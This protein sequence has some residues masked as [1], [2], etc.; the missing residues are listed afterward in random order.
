MKFTDE[1]IKKALSLLEEAKF[2]ILAEEFLIRV[3]HARQ[4]Y[5]MLEE[6]LQKLSRLCKLFPGKV[7]QLKKEHEQ[8]KLEIA[9]EMLKNSLL[10]KENDPSSI[11]LSG[12]PFP[13]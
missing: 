7:E 2:G 3:G 5:Y 4:H 10:L 13:I 12:N 8:T 11:S 9:Q 6:L 1:Q